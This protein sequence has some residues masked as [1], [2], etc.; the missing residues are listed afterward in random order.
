MAQRVLQAAP[1]MA[2][3]EIRR[4]P[5]RCPPAEGTATRAS[6]D[7]RPSDPRCWCSSLTSQP[8]KAGGID[9]GV[10]EAQ[11]AIEAILGAL[12]R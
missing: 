7:R 12:Q 1:E 11:V 9:R 10:E 5:L 3:K 6:A 8:S 4:R 2:G